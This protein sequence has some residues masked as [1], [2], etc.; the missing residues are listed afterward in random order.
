MRLF[1]PPSEAFSSTQ[2]GWDPLLWGLPVSIENLA[3]FSWSC[4][5]FTLKRRPGTP[6]PVQHD[7]RISCP[8]DQ[9]KM[10]NLKHTHA[11]CTRPWWGSVRNRTC[12]S[13]TCQNVGSPCRAETEKTDRPGNPRGCSRGHSH[14][15]TRGP[16]WGHTG[17]ATRGIK[18][19]GS[20]ALCLSAR[21]SLTSQSL[22]F[23]TVP[24]EPLGGRLTSR[25]AP[26]SCLNL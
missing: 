25:M 26:K 19:R 13:R 17:E 23:G 6:I 16:T 3:N 4:P 9:Q 12:D 22:G 11:L 18:F 15:C 10:A 20:R 14:E 8:Q 2:R 24:Y 1:F 7:S 5:H 21:Q